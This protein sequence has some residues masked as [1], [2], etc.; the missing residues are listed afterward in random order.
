VPFEY[1]S[2]RAKT[3]QTLVDF[4]NTEL[5][6]GSTFARSAL[7]AFDAGHTEHYE[8]AKQ[9]AIRALESV[10]RFKVRVVDG[11]TRSGIA[12]KLDALERQIS[13]L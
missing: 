11:K 8:L 2:I 6:L 5:V 1:E 10:R 12:D 4:L 13:A 9:R 3:Q 7:L